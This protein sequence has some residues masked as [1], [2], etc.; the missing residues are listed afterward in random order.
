MSDEKVFVTKDIELAAFLH[1]SEIR[2]VDIRKNDVGKTIFVFA[3]EAGKVQMLSLAF[4]NQED[5]I[6]ASK[7]LTSFGKIKQLLFDPNLERAAKARA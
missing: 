7:L 3:N 4:Y 2:I 6:S 5:L 1:A